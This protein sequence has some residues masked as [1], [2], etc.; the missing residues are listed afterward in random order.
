MHTKNQKSKLFFLFTLFLTACSYNYGSPA[1]NNP[2][3]Y[4]NSNS[5]EINQTINSTELVF[6]QSADPPSFDPHNNNDSVSTEATSQIFE[7]LTTFDEN[8]TVVGLLA[9]SFLNLDD[10]TWEFNIRSGVYFH[11]GAYL[12]AQAVYTSLTRLL[13]PENASVRAF[14]LSAISE[15]VIIDE[16][17]IQI[18]TEVPFGPLPAHLANPAGKIISPLAIE[19]EAQD[20][21][22]INEN[23]IGTG[24]FVFVSRAHGA[25]TLFERFEEYWGTPALSETLR[26]VSVTEPATRSAMLETGEGHVTSLQPQQVANFIGNGAVNLI[27]IPMNRLEYI[28]FNTQHPPFDNKLVRQALTMAINRE[29]ILYGLAEGMGVLAHNPIAPGI[30]IAPDYSNLNTLEH[31]IELAKTLLTEAGFPNGF[32]TTIYVGYGNTV[33]QLTAEY[34]QATL[35]QIGVTVHINFMEWG[36]FLDAIDAGEHEMYVLGWTTTTGDPDMAIW[37]L[38]H[39]TM[40]GPSGNTVF[41]TNRI[42]DELLLRGRGTL[43]L[44]EREEIYLE[45]AQI[46]I[47]TAA[48]IYLYHPFANF[49]VRTEIEGM[50]VNSNGV[51]FFHSAIINNN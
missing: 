34:V 21:L 51:P 29:N 44:E 10:Y 35:A 25:Y 41:H 46:L 39:S 36:A 24:P 50:I 12:N 30:S 7:T 22:T 38:Y 37:P 16:Y 26:F 9:Y 3:L 13:D 42:V 14:M 4:E 17:T 47:D 43:D 20:G 5:S 1:I 18:I 8:G 15:V 32:E 23:P 2:N 19:K 40:H 6:I 45:L 49:G 48:R 33:R 11:D 28:G 31:N 27:Q